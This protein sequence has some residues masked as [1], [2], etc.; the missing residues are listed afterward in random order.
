MRR[1]IC[2]LV[3]ADMSE[4]TF[5]EVVVNL[6][7]Y[8]S[9][10]LSV[11]LSVC[12]SVHPSVQITPFSYRLMCQNTIEWQTVLS[13]VWTGSTLFAQACL[14][15]KG[16]VNTWLYLYRIIPPLSKS[17]VGHMWLARTCIHPSI[18]PNIKYLVSVP[19][20][21]NSYSLDCVLTTCVWWLRSRL[22]GQSEI[23]N[24][25]RGNLNFCPCS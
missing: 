18:H 7:I 11:C 22:R 13:G 15:T 14:N 2:V 20:L 6:S 16:I 24:N 23:N 10:Y 4:C 9:I 1:Q 19:S 3:W 12:P 21:A 17:N 5:S 25:K 8:L